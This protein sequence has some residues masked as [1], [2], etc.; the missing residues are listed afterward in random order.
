MLPDLP[1]QIKH[2]ETKFSLLFRSWI[3]AHPR[4]TCSIELK[5]TRGKNSFPFSEVKQAQID[6][7]LAISSD[8]GVL[9]RIQPIVEGLPD[10]IWMRNE[11][12]YV[13]IKFSHSFSIISIGTFVL[14]KERS[15]RKSLTEERA[16]EIS[17]I[18]VKL[19]K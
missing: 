5:D 1:K 17:V 16:K 10:Y 4:Y 15:K 8:K 9:I 18:T 14:E 12:A 7:A 11:P 3:K 6:W 19:K 13:I 2:Q